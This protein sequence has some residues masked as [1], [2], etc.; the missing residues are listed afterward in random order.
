[1]LT[2]D[3][4]ITLPNIISIFR[5]VSAPLFVD[6]IIYDRYPVALVVFLIAVLSDGVDGLIARLSNQRSRVG[7]YLDPLAD[8]VLLTAAFVTLSYFQDVPIWLTSI[9]VSRD[10][11]L[12]IGTLLWHLLDI[13]LDITPMWI[14]KVTTVCQFGYIAAVLLLIVF[15]WPAPSLVFLAWGVAA[16]TGAS[17]LLY[18]MRGIHVMRINTVGS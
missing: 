18:I 1:M 13:P 12:A 9:V 3:S 2:N 15:P 14:G 16:V 17:G 4:V 7:L 8:K 11:I 10:L 6:L 5:V